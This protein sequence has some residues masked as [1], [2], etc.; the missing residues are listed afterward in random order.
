MGIRTVTRRDL[1][2]LCGT[3]LALL[4]PTRLAAQKGGIP[5]VGFLNSVSPGPFA[6]LVAAFREGLAAG[7]FVEPGN[8]AIEFRWAEGRYDRLPALAT[9]LVDRRVAVIVAT[10]GGPSALAAKRATDEVPIV[11]GGGGDPVKMGLVE[12]LNR[13]G[14]NATGLYQLLIGLEPKRLE[15]LRQLV[16]NAALIAVLIN[17]NNPDAASQERDVRAAA[18]NFRQAIVLLKAATP[19]EI[20]AAFDKASAEKADALLVAGDPFFNSRRDQITALAARHRIPADYELREFVMAGG[21]MSYGPSLAN[22]YRQMGLYAAR[23]LKGA[24]PATLPVIQPTSFELVLNARAAKTLGIAFPAA[25]LAQA[26][27]VVE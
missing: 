8:V 4:S 24:E 11:F 15:L 26:D 21:L 9:E 14:G 12:S 20:D 25:L 17:P 7:G 1:L 18:E 23:I 13:P 3:A 22:S 6:H 2:L 10:G 5:V 27:E 19:A 16:P